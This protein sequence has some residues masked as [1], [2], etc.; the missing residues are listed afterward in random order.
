MPYLKRCPCTCKQER[1]R[2]RPDPFG[3]KRPVGLATECAPDLQREADRIGQELYRNSS[4][5]VLVAIEMAVKV[6]K[7]DSM[8]ASHHTWYHGPKCGCTKCQRCNICGKERR[9]EDVQKNCQ[10]CQRVACMQC[11]YD[12]QGEVTI[13]HICLKPEDLAGLDL[14]R[15][16]KYMTAVR[17]CELVRGSE[18][19]R[20]TREKKP[21]NNLLQYVL[22][23]YDHEGNQAN[24]M[25]GRHWM[26]P[27]HHWIGEF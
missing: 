22:Y 4:T 25:F 17:E 9:K 23:S 18:A 7:C 27:V 21:C 15:S 3:T 11:L 12:I 8:I 1:E 10:T 5:P 19:K 6:N 2:G 14:K 16:G 26:H 20:G 13:C 24:P